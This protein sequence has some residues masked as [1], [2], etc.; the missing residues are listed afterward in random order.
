MPICASQG[1]V[2]GLLLFLFYIND[3][4]IAIKHCKVHHFADD[5][6]LLYTNI[7]IEKLNKLLN[8]DLKIL[9]NWLDANKA[10]LNVDKTEVILFKRTKKL[11]DCSLQGRI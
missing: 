10:S 8:K 5:T 7:S 4:N 2:L 1:S 9:T 11:L 6:H 3:L